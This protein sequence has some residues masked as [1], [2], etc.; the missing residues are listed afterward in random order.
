MLVIGAG[1]VGASIASGLAEQ[2]AE[3]TLLDRGEPGGGTSATSFAWVNANG[4]EPQ[5]YFELNHAGLREH[6]ALGAGGRPWWEPRG[7]LQVAVDDDHAVRLVSRLE[8]LRSRGYAVREVGPAGVRALE[9]SLRVPGPV[10]VAAFFPDE[11]HLFPAA[12]VEEMVRRA[13]AAGA[14]VLPHTEVTSLGPGRR[15]GALVRASPGETHAADVVVSAVGRW[16]G[17]LAARA[18][19]QVPMAS[20]TDPGDLTVGFLG[21][22]TPVRVGVQRVVTTPRVNLRPWGR[23]RLLVQGLDLDASADPGRVPPVAGTVG[24][25]LVARVAELLPGS[26][27][28]GLETLRVGQRAMPAD[29]LTVVGRAPGMDWLYVVATHSGITLAPLLGRGVAAEVLG[30]H[31][32]LFDRFRPD[33]F[34]G[35]PR[36]AVA[37]PPAPRRPGEQ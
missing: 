20:F 12:Y 2:G 31:E 36:T 13:R 21:M 22:T 33:R 35:A 26:G 24:S 17:G 8:R 14:R 19:V 25:T 18:G 10:Q 16:T 5:H 3:V 29:G 37:G 1:V 11:A 28:V 7:H 23:G 6:Q 30:G 4:K 34:D 15:G 9:P 32:A 27:D